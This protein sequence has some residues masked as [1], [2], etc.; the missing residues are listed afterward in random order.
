MKDMT[1]DKTIDFIK[2]D[3]LGIERRIRQEQEQFFMQTIWELQD[4]SL[5]KTDLK[6]FWWIL[7]N[8]QKQRAEETPEDEPLKPFINF[9]ID[10]QAVAKIAE[11][12]VPNIHRT[13]RKLEKTFLTKD[14]NKKYSL[15]FKSQ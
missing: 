12:A 6:I 11:V 2:I 4:A 7:N 3:N 5:S 1:D 15:K 8:V 10:I 9:D 13:L 14:Q